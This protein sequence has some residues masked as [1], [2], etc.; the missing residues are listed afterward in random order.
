MSNVIKLDEIR[1][2]RSN[3]KINEL[4]NKVDFDELMVLTDMFFYGED[5]DY[6]DEEDDEEDIIDIDKY[7]KYIRDNEIVFKIARGDWS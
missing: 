3:T 5:D 2:E 7:S 4:F 6:D 1:R